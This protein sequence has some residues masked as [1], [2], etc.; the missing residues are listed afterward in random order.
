MEGRLLGVTTV[1]STIVFDSVNMEKSRY[2]NLQEANKSYD[3]YSVLVSMTER[4]FKPTT[5][6]V[7]FGEFL[8]SPK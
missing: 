3:V 8:F 7:C 5:K 2:E 1:T 6:K 4:F